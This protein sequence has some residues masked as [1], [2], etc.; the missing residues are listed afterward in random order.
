ML[1]YKR[2]A[3]PV[4]SAQYAPNDHVACTS[5][6]HML[7]LEHKNSTNKPHLAPS[8]RSPFLILSASR[9][10]SYWNSK[11]LM[12]ATP[13]CVARSPKTTHPHN[14]RRMT[15]VIQGSGI[16]CFTSS[17]IQCFTSTV[18]S[19]AEPMVP[20]QLSW[21]HSASVRSMGCAMLGNARRQKKHETA[22]ST[23]ARC[24]HLWKPPITGG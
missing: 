11:Q 18:K 2:C 8:P 16:Q 1:L 20:H 24:G 10:Q 3:H 6:R 13:R 22:R 15:E 9:S 5:D 23:K 12:D 19:W 14:W 17:G 21:C 4:H 7:V